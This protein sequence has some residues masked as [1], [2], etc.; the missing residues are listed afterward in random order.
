MTSKKFTLLAVLMVGAASVGYSQLGG[1][2]DYLDSSKVKAKDLPQYNEWKSGS[3]MSTFPPKPRHMGQLGIFG[4]LMM[5]DGDAPTLPGWNAGI[6]YRRAFG[7]TI[8]WRV[9]VGYGKVKTLD[10]RMNRNFG[11]ARVYE[12]YDAAAG[13]P[14]FFVHSSETTVINPSADLLISLNNI[15][16]HRAK[17]KFNFYLM[18]GYSPMLYK[19]KLD[20][21]N[22]SA[23]YNFGG[24]GA[25]FFARERGDIRD[26]LKDLF[27]GDYETV[28]RVNDRAQNFDDGAPDQTQWRHTFNTG[29]GTE[30][31]IA[32]R[33]SLSFEFKYK[34]T[35]DDYIDGW[36]LNNNVAYT[37]DKDNLWFTNLSLNF[38]L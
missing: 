11:N 4:G 34:W 14:D 2:I 1:V 31:R 13:G 24:L 15:M 21:L 18:A 35:L 29:L 10:Y 37:A 8:S 9:G 26:D 33:A 36:F 7:Y 23:L 3:P 27:D 19:T 16:F 22:G 20:A 25:G 32:P 17:S 38:N 6:S 30:M 12:R 5:M 28:A